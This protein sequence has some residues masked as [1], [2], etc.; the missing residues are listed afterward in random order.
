MTTVVFKV[1]HPPAYRKGQLVQLPDSIAWDLADKG[2][3]E[4]RDPFVPK[5]TKEDE[6]EL[7]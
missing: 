3:V 2:V 5:E 6:G 4:I 1:E 7:G